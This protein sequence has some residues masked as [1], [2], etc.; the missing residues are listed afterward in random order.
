MISAYAKNAIVLGLLSAVG[1]FAIDMYLPALPTIAADLNASTASTQ[2]TLMAF[3]VAMGLCQIVYGLISDMAGRKP[4]LYA[5]LTLFILGSIGCALSPG[6]GALIAFRFLQGIGASAVMV[7]PRAVI[8]DLHTGIEATRLTALV[9]LV[10]SVS[11][12]LAP[13]AGSALIV[14]FG[15]RAV[16]VT[17]TVVAVLAFVLTALFLPETRPPHDRVKI[18]LRSVLDGFGRLLR[19]W[20]FLG[21][22]FIG[23]LGMASFFAFIASSS[24][25][26]TDHYG[27]TPIAYSFA[28]SINAVGFIGAS[29]F[30]AKLGGRFG[31]GRVVLSATFAYALF[32]TILL[33]FNF[34]GVDSL[35]VMIVLLF[36]GFTAMGLVIPS[37]MV[38][39]L[40]EHGPIAGLA[41]ALGGTLQMV[42]GGIMIVIVSVVSDGTARPMVTIIALC[43][44]GALLLSVATMGRRELAPQLAE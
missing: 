41:S 33:G 26:Y 21:L 1:P 42:T 25:I 37:T 10:L 2:M 11:P 39:A 5:G 22:T 20:H 27:L 13:L 31:T 16:F 17:I 40:E 28:F 14:S 43:A 35:A 6:I 4:P 32:T 12:M 3:F 34:A 29:Q 19:D 8:R 9:M 7:V 38:L 23:A 24:F 36:L 30:A 44:I 18:S 15:W